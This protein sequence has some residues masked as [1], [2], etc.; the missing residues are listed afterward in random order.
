MPHGDATQ[1]GD[2]GVSL[3]GGQKARAEKIQLP[4]EEERRHGTVGWR[5]YYEYFKAGSGIFI[6]LILLFLNITAQVAYVA[7]DWWLSHW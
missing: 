7:S 3:S 4:E 2:R 5:I 1:I 6:F